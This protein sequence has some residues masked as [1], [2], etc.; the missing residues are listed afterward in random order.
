MLTRCKNARKFCSLHRV[1]VSC[2][3]LL[4]DW[5]EIFVHFMRCP[6]SAVCFY[7]NI[8]FCKGNTCSSVILTYLFQAVVHYT[9]LSIFIQYPHLAALY[10]WAKWQYTDSYLGITVFHGIFFQILQVRLPNSVLHCGKF[11]TYSN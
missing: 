6:F 7:T 8:K 2:F 5:F 3:N 9:V 10:L 1:S 11:S 4:A